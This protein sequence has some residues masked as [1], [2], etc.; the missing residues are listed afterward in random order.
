AFREMRMKPPAEW[1]DRAP[2]PDDVRWALDNLPRSIIVMDEFDRV[3]DDESLSLMSDAIKSLSD[4]DIG[5][6]VVI[7]GVA[8]SLDELVGDHASVQRAIEEVAMP[9]MTE[10]EAFEIIDNGLAAADMTI[11]PGPRRR[12]ARLSEGLPHYIHLLALHG[13]RNAVL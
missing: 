13:A 1:E 10:E 12:I 9:R 11:K 6:K 7:V 2:D 5:T 8:D 4:H 3:E